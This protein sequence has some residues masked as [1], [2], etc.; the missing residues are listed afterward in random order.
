MKACNFLLE[1]NYPK[2]TLALLDSGGCSED[3][4]FETRI[5]PEQIQPFWSDADLIYYTDNQKVCFQE[6][7]STELE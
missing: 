6:R 1:C 3:K 2:I 7:K 4:V 5:V